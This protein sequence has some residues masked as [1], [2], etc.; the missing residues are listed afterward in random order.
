MMCW[1]ADYTDE[2]QPKHE[3]SAREI[4]GGVKGPD[5]VL[6]ED[7]HNTSPFSTA[8]LP[9]VTIPSGRP[10]GAGSSVIPAR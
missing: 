1:P 2:R 6:R 10:R 4:E 8:A 7:V 3:A 5:R 9:F